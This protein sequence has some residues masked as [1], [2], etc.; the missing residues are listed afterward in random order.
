MSDEVQLTKYQ[1]AVLSEIISAVGDP[2]ATLETIGGHL[3]Q[4]WEDAEKRQDGQALQIIGTA[5]EYVQ[6][7]SQQQGHAMNLA[8][9]AREL[10]EITQQNLVKAQEEMEA[11]RGDYDDLI[12]AIEIGD[13]THELLADYAGAIREEAEQN[14]MTY[15]EDDAL[16]YAFERIDEDFDEALSVFCQEHGIE[17]LGYNAKTFLLEKTRGETAWDERQAALWKQIIEIE[18]ELQVARDKEREQQYAKWKVEAAKTLEDL[19]KGRAAS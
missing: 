18:R 19:A 1:E 2:G 11:V 13:E 14:A 7:M 8:A 12:S 6:L 10:A 4:I 5:W 17:R 3:G 9:A 15:L 16:S